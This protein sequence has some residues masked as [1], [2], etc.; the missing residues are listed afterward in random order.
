MRRLVV[1]AMAFVFAT[2]ANAQV[3]LSADERFYA[4]HYDEILDMFNEDCP[5]LQL[6]DGEGLFFNYSLIDIDGDGVM[7]LWVHEIFGNNGAFFCRGN[8]TLELITTTWFKSFASRSGNV[9]CAS[10]PAGTGAFFSSYYVIEN[11]TIAHFASEIQMYNFQTD[12]IDY[13]CEYD[14]KEVKKAWFKEKLQNNDYVGLSALENDTWMPYDRLQ[15]YP[16]MPHDFSGM[17][18]NGIFDE[19]G[20]LVQLKKLSIVSGGD[21][22]LWFCFNPDAQNINDR[23]SPKDWK[24]VNMN[25]N[26]VTYN[27]RENGCKYDVNIEF[28]K[29]CVYVYENFNGAP[30]PFKS[31]IKLSGIYNFDPNTFVDG[32]GYMYEFGDGGVELICGGRYFGKVVVP[33]K[34]MYDGEEIPVFGVG[35][36]AFICNKSITSVAVNDKQ[37]VRKSAYCGSGL[38]SS[39]EKLPEFVYANESLTKF[40]KPCSAEN[41]N[42]KSKQWLIF[43]NSAEKCHY[44][45]YH[46]G[47]M[48]AR[49]ID[50]EKAKCEMFEIDNAS[51]VSVM[52]DGYDSYQV[53]ALVSENEYVEF[54]TF[55]EY[56]S[57]NF[58]EEQ[59]PM[60][61]AFNLAMEKKYGRKVSF[62][63][64]IAQ[65]VAEDGIFAM[66][67]F[68]YVN[69]EAMVAFAW[70]EDGN[71]V[72]TYSMK[73]ELSEDAAFVDVAGAKRYYSVWNVDDDGIY[74]IPAVPCIAKDANGNVD[75]FVVHHAPE[76][77][78]CKILRREG[79][80]L[81]EIYGNSWY[82]Y[83]E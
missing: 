28:Y 52:F 40:A 55:P 7:E 31:G 78:V 12:D 81:V 49:C 67:E 69:N 82:N 43:N 77:T 39:K 36:S 33:A 70:I 66:A 6:G 14:G 34:V 18:Y 65:L 58:P 2:V 24:W 53:E 71:I 25:G 22:K 79:D 57:W 3:N 19:E 72:A 9:F 46:N 74:G 8:D 35:E 32:N 48:E 5:V 13:E 27:Y 23:M 50:M 68:E 10:G 17:Y 76:S 64:Q 15:L 54:H 20:A 30:S 80:K 1:I 16:E 21:G 26:V 11:S 51:S 44:V 37:Y 38:K 45:G 83:Y 41:S 62:S 42:E 60:N 63:R 47:E 29:N 61:D 75:L 73:T 4:Q 56:T 59:T